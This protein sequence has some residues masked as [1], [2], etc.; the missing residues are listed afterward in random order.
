MKFHHEWSTFYPKNLSCLS[1]RVSNSRKIVRMRSDTETL[2]K[3]SRSVADIR[4]Y[5][6]SGPPRESI[7]PVECNDILHPKKQAIEIKR[8]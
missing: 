6:Y 7:D 2:Q 5:R 3:I 8:D 1:A 4:K